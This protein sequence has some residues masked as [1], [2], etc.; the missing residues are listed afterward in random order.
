MKPLLIVGAGNFPPEVE[1]LARLN[2]Y[3]TFSFVDDNPESR[4]QP[5][6]GSLM[7][8]LMHVLQQSAVVQLYVVLDMA[9]LCVAEVV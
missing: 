2:S 6:I 3:D 4:C 9:M 1:E 5:E 7:F 8:M